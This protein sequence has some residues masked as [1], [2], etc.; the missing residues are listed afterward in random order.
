[1]NF[2]LSSKVPIVL[3]AP[4]RSPTRKQVVA[5]SISNAV[6]PPVPHRSRIVL[7]LPEVDGQL[8]ALTLHE[9]AH[10]LVAEII[11]PGAGGDGGAPHWVH[12]GMATYMVGA[13]SD[14]QDRLMRDLVASGNLP[15][16]SQ[17]TGGRGFANPL[18]ND[19]LGHAAFDYIESRWGPVRIRRF[20]NALSVPRKPN[21]YESVFDQTPA[22]FD[23]AFRQYMEHRFRPIIR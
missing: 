6:A 21:T 9:L 15:A 8:D 23:A 13:W 14:D 5:Y 3:F 2:V 4:S 20:L 11:N 22:A 7:P 16:L 18:L 17:L 10:L 19:A 1:L 12:E